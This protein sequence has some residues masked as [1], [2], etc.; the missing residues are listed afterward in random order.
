MRKIGVISDTHGLLRPQI[1]DRFQ[2]VD[3]IIHAGDVGS[4]AV[5]D[6][7]R[8][9]APVTAIRGNVDVAD[10]ASELPATAVVEF[11]GLSLYVIHDLTDL[12]LDPQT[13]GFSA[14]LYGHSHTPSQEIHRGIL[15]FNPG[16]SGPFRFHLPLSVG[17]L[18]ISGTQISAEIITLN[19]DRG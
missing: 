14:V 16:S 4:V 17:L 7:L 15:Y 5:I 13:A 19:I 11:D 18:V 10:W 3:H 12:N 1:R 9:I 8:N 6:E 2:G